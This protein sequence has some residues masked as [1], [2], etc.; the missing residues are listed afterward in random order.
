M[1]QTVEHVIP[2]SSPPKLIPPCVAGDPPAAVSGRFSC[3]YDI[4]ALLDYDPAKS[5]RNLRE[6]GIGFDRFAEM[7]LD[8]AVTIDDVRKDYGARGFA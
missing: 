7:D 4:M 1:N 6:R 8:T 3:I 2:S 5:A